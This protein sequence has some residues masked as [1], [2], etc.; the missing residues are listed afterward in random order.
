VCVILCVCE[1]V[2]MFVCVCMCVYMRVYMRVFL[3]QQS[4]ACCSRHWRD[5]GAL[6][7]T[8]LHMQI[9]HELGQKVICNSGRERSYD[10]LGCR[11]PVG[12]KS[13][14]AIRSKC[15]Y[16]C[17]CAHGH[18]CMHECRACVLASVGLL[19]EAYQELRSALY[20]LPS[21]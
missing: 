3:A 19:R 1:F 21:F 18:V 9:S 8:Y 15:E 13:I 2:Y 20:S 6:F 16:L 5:P 4:H 11:A 10:N 12:S 14:E 17:M 7:N